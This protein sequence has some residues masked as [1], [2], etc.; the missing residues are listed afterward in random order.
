M[1]VR[2][3]AVHHDFYGS[4]S[5]RVSLHEQVY[6]AGAIVD[7]GLLPPKSR[8][9]MEAR[10]LSPPYLHEFSGCFQAGAIFDFGLLP[11]KSRNS[12]RGYSTKLV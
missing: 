3:V 4:P 12:A 5:P 6:Q 1:A 7:F 2:R 8:R 11:P 9:K 10:S